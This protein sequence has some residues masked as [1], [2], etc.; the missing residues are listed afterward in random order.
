MPTLRRGELYR[1]RK[2]G[3]NTKDS[4]VF[5]VVS[6][7][8]LLRSA[9]STVICAPVFSQGQRLTTQVALGQAEG[10]KHPGW[11]MCDNLTS[12]RRSDLTDYL[13]ALS[14]SKLR[15]LNEALRSA[16]ALD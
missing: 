10:L 14:S 12:L 13:G 6:R 15:E 1:V 9:F 16:L 5:V 7:D 2:P 3:G 8:V 4:R 11:I